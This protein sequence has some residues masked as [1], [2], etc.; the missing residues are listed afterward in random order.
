MGAGRV[1]AQAGAA[2][3]DVG[4]EAPQPLPEVEVVL[5]VVLDRVGERNCKWR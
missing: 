2:V 4:H 5:V 3:A 1:A